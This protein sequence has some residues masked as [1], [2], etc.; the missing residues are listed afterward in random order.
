MKMYM[1]PIPL[2]CTVGMIK[3]S[4]GRTGAKSMRNAYWD[5]K[6]SSNHTVSSGTYGAVLKGN[7]GRYE[8]KKIL[9][10]K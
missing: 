2:L 6:D 4:D 10:L 8:A 1:L 9:L 5:G 7:E 3:T